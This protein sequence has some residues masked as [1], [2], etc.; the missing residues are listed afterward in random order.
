[1]NVRN[2]TPMSADAIA[3]IGRSRVQ[4]GSFND[5]IYLLSLA[6]EDRGEADLVDALI[7][8]AARED[9]SKIFAKVPASCVGPFVSGGF[10]KEAHVPGM[11]GDEDGVF[12]SFYR[13]PWRKELGDKDALDHVLSVAQSKKDKGNDSALFEKLRMRGLA[14]EDAPELA[15]LYGRVFETYPFPISDPEFLVQGM[16]QGV[17][18]MG[19]FEE[20]EL[21][22]AASAETSGDAHSAEM[23][24]FAVDPDYRMMGVAGALL[25]ALEKDRLAMGV[26]CLFTIARAGSYGM[27]CLFSKAGYAYT[28]RLIN[29]TNIGGG[30]ESMNVWCK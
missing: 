18:F 3:T 28:G 1:M 2:A 14:A 24:D 13:Y 27:N 9:L 20:E 30:L 12:L 11:F 7:N 19:V 8:I 21:I 17:R 5:R 15:D 22:G 23:T 26:A 4:I 10:E 25:H 6:P 29:N 16:R